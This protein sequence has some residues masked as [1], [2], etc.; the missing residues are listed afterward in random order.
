MDYNKMDFK[1]KITEDEEGNLNVS[2]EV[3]DEEENYTENIL[4]NK[5]MGGLG[6]S[7]IYGSNLGNEY[8]TLYKIAQKNFMDYTNYGLNGNPIASSSGTSQQPMC[9]RY[10][11]M[12]NDLDYIVVQGG[13][14]D[15]RLS[16]PIG[17]NTDNVN[18]TFKGALNILIKGLLVKYPNKKILFM[19]NYNRVQGQ[20]S[21]GLEDKDYVDAMIEM[22]GLYG[23]PCFDNYR[24]CGI[25]WYT[26]LQTSWA[27]E[28]VYLG[29]GINRH[30]SPSGYEF[31]IP[32]Y[33]NL[34]KSI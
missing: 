34:L 23:I 8:T 25:S 26:D 29:T 17:E 12:S 19:T 13:A 3:G 5:K 27:D 15:R 18:T 2:I 31:L 22:C 1:R 9:V 32:V 28:G 20:N 7:L 14:N 11:D 10:L 21:I 4:F 24:K 6:D 16:I 30:L 33:E